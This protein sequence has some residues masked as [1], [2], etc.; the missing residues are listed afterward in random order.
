[1]GAQQWKIRAA[2]ELD[3]DGLV[4]IVAEFRDIGPQRTA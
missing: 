1:M 4:P 3:V 2:Q